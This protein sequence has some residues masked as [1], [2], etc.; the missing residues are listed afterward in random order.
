MPTPNVA[1]EPGIGTLQDMCACCIPAAGAAPAA[2]GRRA[3][4]SG[5]E[6]ATLSPLPPPLRMLSPLPPPLRML[7]PLPPPLRM[8]SPLPPPLRMFSPLPPPMSGGRSECQSCGD[9]G[10]AL[11]GANEPADVPAAEPS[12]LLIVATPAPTS[13]LPLLLLQINDHDITAAAI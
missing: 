7:S 2:A 9:G 3:G 11:T 4:F 10:N 12:P 1:A 5:L 13:P 8:L 6:A